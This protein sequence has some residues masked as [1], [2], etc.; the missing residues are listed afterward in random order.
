VRLIIENLFEQFAQ[1]LY[2]S[3]EKMRQKNPFLRFLGW[4]FYG[5]HSE[6]RRLFTRSKANNAISRDAQES[7]E[8]ARIMRSFSL[9]QL[10]VWEREGEIEEGYPCTIADRKILTRKSLEGM[11]PLRKRAR[12]MST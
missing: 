1:R 8:A 5:V 9:E 6:I 2:E 11:V 3:D 7:C 12:A 4:L 10:R